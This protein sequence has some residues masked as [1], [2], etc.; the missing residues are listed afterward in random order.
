VATTTAY[1]VRAKGDLLLA[2]VARD[3]EQQIA[4]GRLLPG[5]RLPSERSLALQLGL[6][7]NT[8]SAAY[9]L[10]EKREVIRRVPHRGA[11]VCPAGAA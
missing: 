3:I 9:L 10:L 7:R 8:V 11:F 4:L 6:S 2:Q 5:D 1:P